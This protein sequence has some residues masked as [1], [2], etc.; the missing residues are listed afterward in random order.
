MAR[1]TYQQPLSLPPL[2][3]AIVDL[4]RLGIAGDTGSVAQLGRRILRRQAEGTSDPAAFR[5]ALGSALI[6]TVRPT[7]SANEMRAPTDS[8]SHLPLALV[9]ASADS[10]EPLLIDGERDAIRRLVDEHIGAET[11]EAAG[12]IPTRTLLLSGPPG[13]G[14]TMTARY[15]ATSLGLPLVTIDLAGLMSSL[16]GRTGQNLRQALDYARSFRCVLLLDEFDALAKRRDDSSDVGELKRI[17]NV[18]LLE[19][20]RWPSGNLL[21]A[22]TNHPELLDRAVGRRF[23]AE[24]ELSFPDLPTRAAIVRRT[25]GGL[26]Q[27]MDGKVTD[28]TAVATDGW[29][30]SDIDRLL[31]SVVRRAVMS[32]ESPESRLL[33]DVMAPLRKATRDSA[34]HRA[35][36]CQIAVGRL[37]WSQRAVAELLGIS[38][39]TVGKLLKE[40]A[41]R[42]QP[43][44]PRR[45]E[46][47]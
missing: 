4:V 26:G 29:S 32:G 21:I 47:Q 33:D 5:D 16:L 38:H 36:F 14:K 43:S 25:L 41:P 44:V 31:H 23:D 11:L 3:A 20:E 45:R 8:E 37:G 1:K 35:L 40:D 19:L 24:I 17:V 46:R 39:P 18:L 12:L 15:I 28:A 22:A 27:T 30:G 6:A 2:E 9:E 13:V 7:R 42:A 34:E 10:P